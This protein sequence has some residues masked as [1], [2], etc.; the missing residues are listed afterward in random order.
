MSR[1]CTT[2]HRA[3][4]ADANFCSVCGQP[5]VT[6]NTPPD[7]R[8]VGLAL[9]VIVSA[10]V[11]L[12]VIAGTRPARVTEERHLRLPPAKAAAMFELLKPRD[13]KVIVRKEADGIRITGTAKECHVLAELGN[14]MVRYE[15]LPDASVEHHMA[16]SRKSW[17]VRRTYKLPKH[18]AKALF[19]ALAPENVPVLVS[20][21][22]KRVRV[23]ASPE[24]QN[25]IHS[26][27]RVL[28]GS[29]P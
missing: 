7:L 15:G 25:I 12:G 19:D 3:Y 13:V 27:A 24:D 11:T 29:R 28:L 10:V 18:K 9:F 21:S 5:L 8:R 14:L 20:W 16:Q 22:G 1:Q 23:D 4:P 26:V 2:C 6:A 17:R